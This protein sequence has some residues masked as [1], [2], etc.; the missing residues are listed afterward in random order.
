MV[1]RKKCVLGKNS[2]EFLGY[3]VDEHGILPLPE[4]V[5]AIRE[6]AQPTS[7]KE[8]QRFLGMINY[9]RRFIPRAAHHLRFLFQALKGKQKQLP[10][11]EK[12]AESFEAIKEALAAATLL[13]HPRSGS[14]LALTTDAS[15]LAI[16]GVLE[17]LGPTGW[18]PL[19]FYSAKLMDHQQEWPPYD[20]ELL[21]AFKSVRHFR[22]FLEGRPFTLF[23]DHLSLVPS[24]AK[25]GEPQT[26]RQ[27]YQL[28]AIAEYTTDFR[29]LEGKA[30]VVVDSLS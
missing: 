10:W 15:K 4:R 27:A 13:H 20:R 6:F 11:N 5:S 12:C 7:V 25:K 1:S 2:L 16:G 8:L 30:N 19:S 24:V 17:Q 3:H 23:T 26:T 14:Q 9:Y 18:E 21:G 28:S 29:Y 22:P